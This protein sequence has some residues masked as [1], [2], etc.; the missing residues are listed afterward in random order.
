MVGKCMECMAIIMQDWT[1]YAW[2]NHDNNAL[3]YSKCN[4]EHIMHD[5]CIYKRVCNI[6][7]YNYCMISLREYCIW[8]CSICI[9]HGGCTEVGSYYTVY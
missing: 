8:Y 1:Y 9:M 2:Q 5:N 7:K 6:H 4:I 3:R